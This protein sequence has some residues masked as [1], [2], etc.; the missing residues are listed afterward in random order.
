[1]GPPSGSKISSKVKKGQHSLGDDEAHQLLGPV[2]SSREYEL[3]TVVELASTL[4][5]GKELSRELLSALLLLLICQL[6]SDRQFFR[7]TCCFG[8]HA[9][10]LFR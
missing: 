8:S 10:L 4:A 2:R 3:V 1:M 5:A 6:A 7:R 9:N